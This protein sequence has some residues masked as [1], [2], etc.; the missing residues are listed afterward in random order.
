MQVNDFVIHAQYGRG[1]VIA[2]L[3]GDLVIVRFDK[4]LENLKSIAISDLKAVSPILLQMAES[5][6]EETNVKATAH[7]QASVIRYVNDTWGIFARSSIDL[8]PHQ[9]W[10][11][12]QALSRWPVGYV[13]ADDVGL[14]KTVEA[15]L[16]MSSMVNARKANRILILTPAKLVTQWQERLLQMF[17]L[18]FSVYTS[19]SEKIDPHYWETTNRVIASFSTLQADKNDRFDHFKSAPAWD[20]I[21]VDEAHHMNAEEHNVTLQ[22][23]FFQMLREHNKVISTVLFTG[24]P[25]RG[26]NY[27]FWS[28]MSLIDPNV[29]GPDF[30]EEEQYAALKD[31]FIRN[32]KQNVVNMKGEKLFTKMTQHPYEFTYSA[33]ESA[34][35]EAMSDFISSG[36]MYAKGLGNGGTAVGLLLCSLQKIASSSLAAITSALRNR[37]AAIK[38]NLDKANELNPKTP[39]ISESYMPDEDDELGEVQK[40]KVEPLKLMEGELVFIDRL[41][42]LAAKV[43]HET[44]ITRII[45]IIK[46]KYPNEQVLLFTEYKRT[47]ALMM[48]E[49][50]KVWGDDCVTI[51]NGD[52][53]LVDIEYPDGSFRSLEVSRNQACEDFNSGKKRFLISTEAAGE[54]IDLQKNCHILIHIDL[55]WNPMRLHQRVGRVHR[56]GQTHDVEVVSVRNPGNIESKIWQYLETKLDEI[57]KMLSAT[58][59]VP[60][61]MQ[62]LVLGMQTSAFFDDVFSGN[63]LNKAKKSLDKWFDKNTKT[64]GGS[65]VIDTA[66][67][68]GLNAAKFNLNGLDNIPKLDLPDLVPFMRNVLKLKGRRLSHDTETD[69]YSFTIPNEWFSFGNMGTLKGQIFR[70]NL[71]TDESPRNISGVG[72]VNV[73]KAIDEAL[74]Y[75]NI[76]VHS[77]GTSSYFMYSIVEASSEDNKVNTRQLF[78]IEFDMNT[79]ELRIVSIDDF[80]KKIEDVKLNSGEEVKFLD[81]IPESVKIFANE[82]Q[83]TMQYK[84]PS[85]EL[86]G[87]VCGQLS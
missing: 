22:Y 52:E 27:G 12:K 11:C 59:E 87:V 47:Q 9:L 83:K 2:I 60:D 25:H 74:Q 24:T 39:E 7:L 66:K 50:M 29:F 23:K 4:D 5:V 86:I 53:K 45:D 81:R 84:I 26:K 62:Q 48:S 44:R 80:Y 54:G 68:L 43:K 38:Y 56:L 65:S 17:D 21:M 18:R 10:V 49:L 70:R 58:M 61:D 69:T 63:D 34:F 40:Q 77:S 82:Y 19:E 41:L 79:N 72:S 37:K 13:V 35:Y 73:N 78:V 71:K 8:L 15:G 30:P 36:F 42:D 14:G 32:N 33:D 46:E 3:P 57:Q 55:P 28:L 64:F 6:T 85:M 51:I 16:I 76:V 75:E 31:Y 1:T 20:L 67:N